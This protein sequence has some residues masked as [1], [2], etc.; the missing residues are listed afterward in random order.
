MWF[1]ISKVYNSDLIPLALL[2]NNHIEGRK[3]WTF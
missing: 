1:I 2:N 3:E